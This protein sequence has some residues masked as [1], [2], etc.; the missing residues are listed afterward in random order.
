MCIKHENL[1][2]ILDKNDGVTLIRNCKFKQLLTVD[3]FI[4]VIFCFAD[5]LD[6][7]HLVSIV[8]LDS[9]LN[10]LTHLNGAT[11]SV[12]GCYQGLYVFELSSSLIG[13]VEYIVVTSF[14][15]NTRL[16]LLHCCI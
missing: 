13:V 3:L 15:V 10:I 1:S 8:I 7:D 16:N 6:K 9:T 4:T 12:L 14:L 5:M 11:I 2:R